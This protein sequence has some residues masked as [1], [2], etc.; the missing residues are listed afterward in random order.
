[1]AL[2]GACALLVGVPGMPWPA[3]LALGLVWGF[4]VVAD[5]AQ[6]SAVVTEVADQSYV[7]TAVTLQLAVGF[8]L[9]VLTIWLVPVLR[10]RWGWQAAFSMLAVGPALGTA[11][12]LR[13]KASPAAARIAGGRG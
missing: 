8:T 12:M 6:F 2:S 13:L 5:S 3:V 9:T 1:M 7:G 10:D 11:A 4:W